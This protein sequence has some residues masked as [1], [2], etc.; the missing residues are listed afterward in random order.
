VA[1]WGTTQYHRGNLEP[2]GKEQKMA[3]PNLLLIEQWVEALRSMKYK[4]GKKVLRS[5][6]DEFCCLGVLCDVA[7]PENWVCSIYSYFDFDGKLFDLSHKMLQEVGLDRN[8]ETILLRMN[9]EQ[10]WPF[11]KIANYLERKY[12]KGQ[13][14]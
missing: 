1:L 5:P 7:H 3:N 10:D 14:K 13:V 6:N 4:Q 8:T 9:D 2:I 12:L 11:S